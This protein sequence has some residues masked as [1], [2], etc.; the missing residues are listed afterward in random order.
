MK[1]NLRNL[2]NILTQPKLVNPETILAV[3]AWQ[4]NF[5]AELR[6]KLESYKSELPKN[7]A[8]I[9]ENAADAYFFAKIDLLKEIL[10]LG[11][12]ET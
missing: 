6:E 1:T 8:Q 2:S 4:I 12:A 7:V 11:E 5:E 9:P 10:G 3:K